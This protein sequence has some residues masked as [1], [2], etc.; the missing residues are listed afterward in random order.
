MF[1]FRMACCAL[2][3]G[4]LLAWG[5]CEGYR[6]GHENSHSNVLSSLHL[7]RCYCRCRLPLPRLAYPPNEH[8]LD[9]FLAHHGAVCLLHRLGSP[10]QDWC[11]NAIQLQPGR[12]LTLALEV[13]Y[14]FPV[15]AWFIHPCSSRT[16]DKPLALDLSTGFGSFV[17]DPRYLDSHH[18]PVPPLCSGLERLEL[19][20]RLC[21]RQSRMAA[22][23]TRFLPG[24]GRGGCGRRGGRGAMQG[25]QLK[26]GSVSAWQVPS[27][28]EKRFQ[29]GYLFA[30]EEQELLQLLMRYGVLQ[31]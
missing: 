22:L 16:A 1:E 14:I 20:D 30:A 4:V 10:Q 5:A 17:I 7:G 3:T 25:V 28:N 9:M 6:F 15:P 12:P 2:Y 11:Q 19:G 26:V 8:V 27:D 23:L 29:E 21:W 18:S 13:S 31:Q 24:R